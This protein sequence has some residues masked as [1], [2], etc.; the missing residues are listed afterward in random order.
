[1]LFWDGVQP[2]RGQPAVKQAKEH[3][4]KKFLTLYES[5]YTGLH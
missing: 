4:G 5:P 3:T 2:V 1:M